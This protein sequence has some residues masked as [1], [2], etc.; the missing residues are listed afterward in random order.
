MFVVDGGVLLH[1]MKRC[2][3]NGREK[4]DFADLLFCQNVSD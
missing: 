1:D 3:P 2:L 4:K